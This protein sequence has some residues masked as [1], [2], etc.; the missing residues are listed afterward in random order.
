V[1]F[2]PHSGG[3]TVD[4]SINMAKR[5][6]SNIV[7]VSKGESLSKSDVVNSEYLK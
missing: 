3:N 1:V 6:I 5:C 7:K 4:N 2:A